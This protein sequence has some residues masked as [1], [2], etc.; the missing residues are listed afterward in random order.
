MSKG[1]TGV[2]HNSANYNLK[3]KINDK[4][5]YGPF[6]SIQL[7]NAMINRHNAQT[8]GRSI[9][10]ERPL[11]NEK[12][13]KSEKSHTITQKI[14]TR[15]LPFIPNNFQEKESS[16]R[17]NPVTH[18]TLQEYHPYNSYSYHYHKVKYPKNEG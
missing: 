16:T 4:A 6:E 3:Q 14:E 10:N 12:D 5:F 1:N 17:W 18:W 7:S 15:K 9:T 13:L 8:S 11:I 2:L